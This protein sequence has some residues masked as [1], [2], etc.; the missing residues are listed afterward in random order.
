VQLVNFLNDECLGVRGLKVYR[1]NE[2]ESNPMYDSR[3]SEDH[4]ATPHINITK[5]CRL[6][7]RYDTGGDAKKKAP[8]KL[9]RGR[10]L[11]WL[12]LVPPRS[13]QF[14]ARANSILLQYCEIIRQVRPG[15]RISAREFERW[16]NHVEAARRRQTST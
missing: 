7:T 15:P 13:I 4:S 12:K 10:G 3:P 6:P 11:T 5:T 2:F 1:I 14:A 16:T 9:N 8:R